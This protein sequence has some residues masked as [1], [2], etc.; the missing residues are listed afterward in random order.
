LQQLDKDLC[1]LNT[2]TIVHVWG[3]AFIAIR[4]DNVTVQLKGN[5]FVK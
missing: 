1:A 4:V 3:A 5:M 2:L